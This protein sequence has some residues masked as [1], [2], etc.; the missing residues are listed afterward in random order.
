MSTKQG[1]D[2]LRCWTGENN[3]CF[4]FGTYSNSDIAVGGGGLSECSGQ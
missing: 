2:V 4:V 3:F 1:M